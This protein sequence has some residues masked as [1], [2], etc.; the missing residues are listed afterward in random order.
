MTAD[1]PVIL[2][3]MAKHSN[4]A[5]WSD[6]RLCSVLELYFCREILTPLGKIDRAQML[7]SQILEDMPTDGSAG[8]LALRNCLILRCIRGS[9]YADG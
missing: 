8:Y 4:H 5:G 3:A 7:Q 2:E 1:E 9:V 6:P